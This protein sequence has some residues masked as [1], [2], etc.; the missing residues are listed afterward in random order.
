[1][2]QKAKQFHNLNKK[3]KSVKLWEQSA[4]PKPPPLQ[5]TPNAGASASCCYKLT[6]KFFSR[7]GFNVERLL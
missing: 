7:F 6:G 3:S 4:I 5:I 2:Y 1:M